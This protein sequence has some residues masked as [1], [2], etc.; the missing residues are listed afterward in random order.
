MLDPLLNENVLIKSVKVVEQA[1]IPESA[2]SFLEVML[3]YTL[4]SRIYLKMLIQSSL[5]LN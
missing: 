5:V 3:S 1:L 2:S 4:I